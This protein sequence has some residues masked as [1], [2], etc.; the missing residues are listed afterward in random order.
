[1]T[2]EKIKVVLDSMLFWYPKIKDLSIPQPKTEILIIEPKDLSKLM[3]EA[4]PDSFTAKV[5]VVCDRM[6]YP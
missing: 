4:V 2:Q 5:K 1:M 6:G 3:N